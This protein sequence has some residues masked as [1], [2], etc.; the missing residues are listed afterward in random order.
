MNRKYIQY[1]LS[2]IKRCAEMNI[3]TELSGADCDELADYINEL[4]EDAEKGTTVQRLLI[5]DYVQKEREANKR[6]AELEQENA[7]LKEEL[8]IM[9]SQREYNK[10]EQANQFYFQNEAKND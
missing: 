3:P 5:E 1:L 10:R 6:I 8:G 9:M 4:T 7:K 2:V